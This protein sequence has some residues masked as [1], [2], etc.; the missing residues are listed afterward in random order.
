M[1]SA[2]EIEAALVLAE[3]EQ[4]TVSQIRRPRPVRPATAERSAR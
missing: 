3:I 1:K 2:L 4:V